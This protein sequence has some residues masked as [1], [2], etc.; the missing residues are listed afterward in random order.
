MTN[1]S[2]PGIQPPKIYNRKLNNA[3]GPGHFFG[4]G[5][6]PFGG[7]TG[8]FNRGPP[9]LDEYRAENGD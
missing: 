3:T 8:I 9:A 2:K 1:Q 7:I 6:G 5:Q 4:N